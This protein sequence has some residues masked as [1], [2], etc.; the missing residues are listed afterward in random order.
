M[1]CQFALVF[2]NIILFGRLHRRQL[3]CIVLFSIR[4]QFSISAVWIRNRQYLIY[5]IVVCCVLFT[6]LLFVCAYLCST[7]IVLCFYVLVV[8]VLCSVYPVLPVSLDCPLLVVPLE[9]SDVYT[10]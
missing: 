6:L 7:H 3:L 5:V 9:F 10:I 8:F 1:P 4:Y 2:C